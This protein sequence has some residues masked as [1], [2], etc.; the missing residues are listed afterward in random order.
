MSTNKMLGAALS[1]AK[2]GWFVFPVTQNQK[3]PAGSL[4]PNGYKDAT[5]SFDQINSWWSQFPNA[6]IGLNLERSGLVCIDID[7]YK[8]ECE[9][10]AFIQDQDL[11]ETLMQKS[12]SGGTHLIYKAN[13]GDDYPGTLCRGVD[14]KYRGYILLSPS[15]FDDTP[16]EWGNSIEP[17]NAPE[18]LSKASLKTAISPRA[19]KKLQPSKNQ[20]RQWSKNINELLCIIDDDGWHN[21]VLRYVGHL[22]AKGLKD[23][24]IHKITDH[25]TL[26]TYSVDQTRQEVQ[27][28]IDGARSKDYGSD[29]IKQEPV[30]LV[31]TSHGTIASNHF[32]VSTILSQQSPW[33]K[34]FAYNEFAD[35]KMVITKP[36]GERGNPSFFKPRDVKDSD[37]TKVLKWL[38]QNGFPT[39]NKQLVIDCV[40]E[41]CEDNIISPVRHYLEG[42][43]FDPVSDKSQLSTWME[44]Y[45]GAKPKTPEEE[46]YVRAVS[47]LSLIQAVA[48]ALTPGCKAD[49]VPILEGGQGVGKST[50]LRILHGPDWFGDALPPMGTKD[51]S[52]YLRGK[53]GIELAELAFQ[54]KADIEAQKA[55]ISKNEERFRPAYG[56]EEIFHPRTCVFWGTTNRSD[57]LKDDTGNRRFLP[58][59]VTQVDIEGLKANR[60]KLW[61]EAVHYFK[62]GEKYWLAGELSKYAEKQANER[63]EED[64][65]IEVINK[66]LGSSEEVSLRGAIE[67][68]FVGVDAKSITQ[69]M[70]RRMSVCLKMA[71]WIRDGKFT[72][73]ERRN[74]ARYVKDPE[75]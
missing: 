16:Y 42:L 23:A 24:E 53:W 65:W 4:V 64:P 68:C 17:A 49:S 45:L 34:V 10:N 58:V 31:T 73:G 1:Y 2:Q 44:I 7:S 38:N 33:N 26:E 61:A 35:R 28:M 60:D 69:Q 72:S 55:F 19:P 14:V 51:A 5:R 59:R 57:Y 30:P 12:A 18:W 67:K 66:E 70:T 62:S 15:R 37:Y 20:A 27:V 40:Q 43:K 71:G 47:R 25:L 36:P 13:K 56:R 29:L 41:L 75:A 48:R 52:D 21:T 22:V 46:Q 9:F 54:R 39:V 8:P 6:N 63:F 3:T 74:Q 11:P 50:A 32:N